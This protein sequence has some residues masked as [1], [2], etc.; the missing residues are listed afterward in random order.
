MSLAYRPL[1]SNSFENFMDKYVVWKPNHT[2]YRHWTI[3]RFMGGFGVAYIFM[4]ELPVRNFWAR[5]L[6]MYIFAAKVL[7]HMKTILPYGGPNGDI[8]ASMD[9]MHH[10]DVRCY[11]YAWR[12]ANFIAIPSSM[13]DVRESVKWYGK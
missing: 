12:M 9:R 5:V 11:D 4:R 6:I 3:D 10:W 1:K 2:F 13:N 7:D 8:I